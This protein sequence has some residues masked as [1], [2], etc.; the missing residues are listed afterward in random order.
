MKTIYN[1]RQIIVSL[2]TLT[3]LVWAFFQNQFVVKII[4]SPFIICSV[5]ILG[6]N[7]FSIL[8]KPKISNI[9]KYIFRISL[10]VYIIGFLTYATYYAIKNKVYSLLIIVGIFI[11]GTISFFKSFFQKK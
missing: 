8:N 10:L 3:I 6:E 4:I 11:L 9:F 7:L 2:I 5:A 1:I